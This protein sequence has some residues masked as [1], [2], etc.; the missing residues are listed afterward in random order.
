MSE[1]NRRD[2]A[3][4]MAL[5]GAVGASAQEKGPEGGGSLGSAKVFT[6][7]LTKAANGSERWN[8]LGGTIATGEAVAM[9]ESVLP[10]GTP[11]GALHVIKHS[12]L[13]VVM[14]G[15]LSFQHEDVVDTVPAGSVAYVAYGTNHLL[16][17]SGETAARYFVF[18]MG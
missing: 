14:E 15:I 4:A 11:K 3:A 17:N 18:Q 6:S 2:F 10:A 9:H 5:F 7:A 16:W 8:V 12:E 1:M 13:I